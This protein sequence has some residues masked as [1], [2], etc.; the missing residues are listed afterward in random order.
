MPEPKI[1]RCDA[2]PPAA[3]LEAVLAAWNEATLRLQ[4]TH[5]ALRSEVRR[6]NDELEGKN[7]ELA[8]QSRLAD[9]G[10]VVAHVAH[11]VRNSLIPFTLYLNLLRRRLADPGD[12]EIMDKLE[13]S[14]TALDAK[15]NDLLHFTAEREPNLALV[16][17]RELVDEVLAGLAPQLAAQGIRA[18]INVAPT[19][20]TQ[21][22]AEMIRRAVLN[23]VLNAIDAMPQG[24]ELVVTGVA[25]PDAVELEIAD[26]GCGLPRDMLPRVFEPFYT[27]KSNGT[28]LGLTIVDH[29]VRRHGGSVTAM[30]CHE[31]GAAFTLRLPQAR[32]QETKLARAA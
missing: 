27:T 17:L 28:G 3:G 2:E 23:L 5:E 10:R 13:S 11:E 19:L 22:D 26:S 4:R 6:L 1:L 29:I 16:F 9:L 24:G 25:C 12:L 15:V 7:Q 18:D 21:A 8:R 31:R 30:N 32:A 20:Q 14:R